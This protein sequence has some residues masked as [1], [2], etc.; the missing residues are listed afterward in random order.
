MKGSSSGTLLL[1]SKT[2]LGVGRW[3]EVADSGAVTKIQWHGQGA[4]VPGGS[5]R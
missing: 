5:G 1:P 4:L 2:L 3:D